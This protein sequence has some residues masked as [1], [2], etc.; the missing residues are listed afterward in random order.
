MGVVVKRTAACVILLLSL[1][2]CSGLGGSVLG[3]LGGPASKGIDAEAEITVGKKEEENS[4]NTQIGDSGDV[5]KNQR[6]NTINIAN[7]EVPTLY[8]V[9]LVLLAGWAIPTPSAMFLGIARG[10]RSFFSILIRGK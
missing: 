3:L 5:V 2:A 6:A 1:S 10:V 7:K 9:L 4:V 8:L